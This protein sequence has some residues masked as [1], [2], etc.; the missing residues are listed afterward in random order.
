MASESNKPRIPVALKNDTIVES[1]FEIRFDTAVPDAGDLLPGMLY[2]QLKGDYPTLTR[3]PTAEIPKAI[4]QKQPNMAFT[5]LHK[6]QGTNRSVSVG[7][8]VLTLSV[9]RPY[10]GWQRFCELITEVV[11]VAQGTKLIASISRVAL[12]YSNIIQ[13]GDSDYDLSPLDVTLR[14]NSFEI[15]GPGTH[16]RS[17]ISRNGCISIAQIVT[18][19]SAN[20]QGK[21]ALSGVML[22]VDTQK[23][24]P[25]KNFWTEFTDTI[26][27]IHNTEKEIFFGLLTNDSVEKLKPTWPH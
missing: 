10:P 4:R 18:C 24:G 5:A 11:E 27:L 16:I 8:Q 13:L 6:L 3:L 17:E 23:V 7:E 15:K 14:L 9:V 12:R 19:A 1:I 25:F 2:P 22:D 26:E 21:E 20:V